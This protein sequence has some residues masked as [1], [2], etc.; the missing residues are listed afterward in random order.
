MDETDEDTSSA[1]VHRKEEENGIETSDSDELCFRHQ[2]SQER[3]GK[4]NML[5]NR[6]LVACVVCLRLILDG[7]A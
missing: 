4:G 5:G 7:C 2:G 3:G 6:D 1:K